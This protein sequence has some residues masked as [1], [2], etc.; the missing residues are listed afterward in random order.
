MGGPP[1]LP[2]DPHRASVKG[3]GL[4]SP[5]R[6]P[7]A[8]GHDPRAISR[9]LHEE[10]L[11]TPRHRGRRRRAAGDA[12]LGRLRR[13]ARVLQ[14]GEGP[15]Q[16]EE[17]GARQARR[18]LDPGPRQSLPLRAGA[19]AGRR[20]DRA[21]R[22]RAHR[23]TRE[24]V[25]RP[26]Q[27]PV[28]PPGRG[29]RHVQGG[30]RERAGDV[31]LASRPRGAVEERA[32]AEPAVAT[33]GRRWV[34]EGREVTLPVVV[35]DAA[36]AA[37]TYL[38]PSAAARR[39]LPGPELDVV[40]LLPGRALFSVA[41]ID[42]RDNDPGDYNEVSRAL[43]VRARG[44]RAGIPYLG[45]ALDFL[46]NRVATWI[47]K[48]P[49]DQRFTC[50]AGRG[51]WG[52]PKSVAQI[53]FQDVDG[54]RRCRLVMDGRHVLTFSVARRCR[55]ALPDASMMTDTYLHDLVP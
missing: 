45:T 8:H 48:L 18:A 30:A 11:C 5:D 37:A 27:V 15:R 46:R 53:E 24:E 38:V 25:P 29:A 40:E 3:D 47:W 4:G 19:R 49:V 42:Y 28:P 16:G 1:A 41:A 43:F 14:H 2:L 55:R 23:R 33:T 54:R 35:R 36:S 44:A 13:H 52:F 39:L 10:G 21:G 9:S 6:I 7:C 51:I 17:P 34:F 32:M 50:A 20:G 22:R 12:R 31:S 26:G